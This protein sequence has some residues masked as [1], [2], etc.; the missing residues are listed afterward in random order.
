VRGHLA[1]PPYNNGDGLGGN[2]V[3]LI[4]P[5]SMVSFGPTP[6]LVVSFVEIAAVGAVG[7]D[8]NR[9]GCFWFSS[10]STTGFF[11]SPAAAAFLFLKKTWIV[12]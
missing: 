7:K 9:A 10:L 4:W 3:N 6:T 1:S 2:F 11:H 8:G 12:T 5:L